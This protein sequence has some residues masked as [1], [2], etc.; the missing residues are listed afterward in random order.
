MPQRSLGEIKR[1]LAHQ[2]YIDVLQTISKEKVELADFLELESQLDFD[3]AMSLIDMLCSEILPGYQ[4]V[5]KIRAFETEI[6]DR[7]KKPILE[8]KEQ[9]GDPN[10]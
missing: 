5:D 9:N 6:R 4:G 3:Q 1:E 8:Q 2:E 10:G 7:L